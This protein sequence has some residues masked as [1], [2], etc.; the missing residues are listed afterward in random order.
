MQGERPVSKT[1]AQQSSVRPS[2]IKTII[3]S[4]NH[5]PQQYMSGQAPIRTYARKRKRNTLPRTR[6]SPCTCC[7]RR[8]LGGRRF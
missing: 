2:P 3:S 6:A 7:S 4:N 8:C 1:Y 5:L